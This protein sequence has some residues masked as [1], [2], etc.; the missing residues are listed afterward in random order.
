LLALIG[1]IAWRNTDARKAPTHSAA[2]SAN[3][4]RRL[5]R[6]AVVALVVFAASQVVAVFVVL[7]ARRTII[8]LWLFTIRIG[9][10]TEPLVRATF[11]FAL[12]LILCRRL[13]SR[14]GDFI[15]SRGFFAMALLVTAWLA[16][17][18]RPAALGRPVD[19]A[20]P[21]AWLLD[22]VPGFSGLRVP[23][24]FGMIVALM[25]AILGGCGAAVLARR[26]AGRVAL[27][28]LAAAFLLEATQ[29][30]FT[31]NGVTATTRYNLPEPRLQ[32]PT[33]G[34]VIYQTIAKLTPDAVLVELP[35]GYADFDLRAMYYSLGHRRPVVNGYSGFMPV[36]YGRTVTAAGELPRHPEQSL[37]AL[38][39]RGATHAVVHESAF[40]GSEGPD[41]T[42]ALIR[43][44]GTELFRDG[45]DVLVSLPR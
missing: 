36:G 15:R 10:A 4:Q 16:L 20:A 33:R 22:H 13:R 45:S 9:D 26:R 6:V 11:A 40:L 18:P 34:P 17:G 30:P 43:L 27:W 31:V 1:V 3:G 24:R 2:S 44:G 21:Y 41:T 8:D 39:A 19:I 12:A 29:V 37:E 5:I 7:L 35:L 28:V 32:R 23:A 42:A 38:R 25:L 14:T